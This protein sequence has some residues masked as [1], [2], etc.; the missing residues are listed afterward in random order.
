MA[1]MNIN[2]FSF[3]GAHDFEMCCNTT[4][5]LEM[6]PAAS[7]PLQDNA[8]AVSSL[9]KQKKSKELFSVPGVGN[10]GLVWKTLRRWADK[11]LDDSGVKHT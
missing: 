10:G 3:R 5:M 4:F 2:I 11:K 9:C 7:L 6:T 1:L 8:A